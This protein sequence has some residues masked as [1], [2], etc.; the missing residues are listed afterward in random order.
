MYIT[1]F[2]FCT[3]KILFVEFSSFQL[4]A[5]KVNAVCFELK[6]VHSCRNLYKI[7]MHKRLKTMCVPIFG[8]SPL[9]K[10]RKQ[11]LINDK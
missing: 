1:L 3:H 5:N 11:Q 7:Q 8:V 4:Y 2:I 9:F 6:K 10:A